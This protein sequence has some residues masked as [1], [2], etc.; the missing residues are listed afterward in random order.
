MYFKITKFKKRFVTDYMTE[1][2]CFYRTSFLSLKHVV[3][4][5]IPDI[6]MMDICHNDL[7]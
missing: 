6:I 2:I 1:M 7:L 4:H 5:I 3:A